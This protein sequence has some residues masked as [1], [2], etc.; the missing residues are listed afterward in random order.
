MAT[1]TLCQTLFDRVLHVRAI[2]IRCNIFAETLL[3]H[4]LSIKAIYLANR[5][6]TGNGQTEI[7]KAAT[8]PSN[9]QSDE[10]TIY[11]QV[12]Q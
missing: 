12:I 9:S 3:W 7:T 10:S 2:N 11:L 5:G 6:S 8:V 4:L 1:V